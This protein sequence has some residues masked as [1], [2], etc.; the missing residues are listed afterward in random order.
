MGWTVAVI[1]SNVVRRVSLAARGTLYLLLFSIAASYREYVLMPK[2]LDA[3]SQEHSP[4]TFFDGPQQATVVST[5]NFSG[6]F[7]SDFVIRVSIKHSSDVSEEKE[8]IFCSSDEKRK[9][10]C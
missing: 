1:L 3:D 9:N 6:Q 4:S 7:Q 2:D 5:S 8:H 10:R